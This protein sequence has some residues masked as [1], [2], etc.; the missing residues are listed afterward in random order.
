MHPAEMLVTCYID[1]HPLKY[2]NLD[3]ES[4]IHLAHIYMS[5][6]RH[7]CWHIVNPKSNAHLVE[8]SRTLPNGMVE[9]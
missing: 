5:T 4:A 8:V 7:K 9:I 3:V 6:V 1:V 2:I